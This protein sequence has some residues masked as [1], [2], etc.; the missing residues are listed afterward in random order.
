M[1]YKAM[2]HYFKVTSMVSDL[3]PMETAEGR[4]NLGILIH[5]TH[6]NQDYRLISRSA[7]LSEDIG[8][9]LFILAS[10]VI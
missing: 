8:H 6:G 3:Y 10:D 5:Y 9:I 4:R 2:S 1:L 7:Q